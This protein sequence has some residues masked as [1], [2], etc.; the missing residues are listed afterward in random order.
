MKRTAATAALVLF[1]LSAP[2]VA[3]AHY[4]P[5][6]RHP[7]PAQHIG[8]LARSVQH[9]RTALAWISR[10]IQLN[11]PLA[12][13]LARERRFHR[14]ALRWQSRQLARARAR[15]TVYTGDWITATRIVGRYYGAR[16][17]DWLVSCSAS[18]GG[19][20]R[21]VWHGHVAPAAGTEKPGGWMQYFE[22]TWNT[23]ARWTFRDAARRGLRVSRR[24]CS[25]WEPLGQAVAAGAYYAAHGN[26]GKWTGGNC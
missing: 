5:K 11:A 17:S 10:A 18:E 13:Y 14:N 26:T 22:S 2:G 3:R 4:L 19:H 20:G 6:P 9:D 12:R 21:W 1:A 23:D 15:L 24:A 8:Y 16:V 25:Y 7:T